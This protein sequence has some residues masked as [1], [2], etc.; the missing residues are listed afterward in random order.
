LFKKSS[1]WK[2]RLVVAWVKIMH[3]PG[4]PNDHS[5]NRWP[6]P[7]LVDVSA[8]TSQLFLALS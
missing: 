7:R 8:Q 4:M 6:Q 3:M 1:N 5:R 2:K